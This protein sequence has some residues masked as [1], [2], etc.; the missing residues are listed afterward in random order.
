MQN[1]FG[2]IVFI[3]NLH[4]VKLFLYLPEKVSEITLFISNHATVF[5]LPLSWKK[6]QSV[7]IGD[8]CRLKEL[9]P[10]FVIQLDQCHF[11]WSF[12]IPCLWS[13]IQ[14][15]TDLISRELFIDW[16]TGTIRRT[17]H[18][19]I[20]VHEKD[21]QKVLEIKEV[22][23]YCSFLKVQTSSKQYVIK[24]IV[25]LN[26]IVAK[27]RQKMPKF[28]SLTQKYWKLLFIY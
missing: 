21:R 16:F 7:F 10:M 25:L 28:L 3:Q 11:Y 24:K 26:M 19:L 12:P 5:W 27:S 17:I 6:E 15:E 2:G 23:Y 22:Q 14:V 1:G 8:L 9:N 18:A 4:L 20:N 13:F